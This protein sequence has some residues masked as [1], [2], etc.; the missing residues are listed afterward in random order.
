M[1]MGMGGGRGGGRGGY[2]PR[3]GAIGAPRGGGYNGRGGIAGVPTGPMAMTNPGMGGMM[4][5]REW[6][7]FVRRCIPVTTRLIDFLTSQHDDESNDGDGYE[8]G[9]DGTDDGADATRRNGRWHVRWV[10]SRT[11]ENYGR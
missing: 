7:C 8:S 4:G 9:D 3:G 1:G 2:V 6:L 5:M 10:S 11:K